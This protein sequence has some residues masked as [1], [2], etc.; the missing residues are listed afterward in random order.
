LGWTKYIPRP[1]FKKNY[2]GSYAVKDLTIAV[3]GRD[4]A[5]AVVP[6]PAA[7]WTGFALLG[8]LGILVGIQK[9]MSRKAVLA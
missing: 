5:A 7:A 1:C 3:D 8:G 2:N 6:L 4:Y 9:R